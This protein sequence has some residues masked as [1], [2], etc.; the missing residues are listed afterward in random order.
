MIL[1]IPMSWR[2]ESS[3]SKKIGGPAFLNSLDLKKGV[4]TYQGSSALFGPTRTSSYA[5]ASAR[6]LGL[7]KYEEAKCITLARQGSS[8]LL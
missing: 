2:L 8:W 4:I 6:G 1:A 5:L 7:P 3:S